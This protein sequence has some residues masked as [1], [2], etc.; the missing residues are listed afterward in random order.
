MI[1]N[2]SL[3][4][5]LSTIA[6]AG[7]AAGL[8]PAA[9]QAGKDKSGCKGKASCKGMKADSTKVHG[10]KADTSSCSGNG[11][12]GGVAAPMDTLDSSMT[13]RKTALLAATTEAA[14]AAACKE[15][16]KEASKASC[17]GKNSCAGIYFSGDKAMEVSCKGK[18]SCHGLSCSI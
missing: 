18:A 6:L 3:R 13:S 1:R 17:A 9:A 12:C 4:L 2:S 5:A 8:V 10:S 16:G 11:K 14:F 15:A 7:L